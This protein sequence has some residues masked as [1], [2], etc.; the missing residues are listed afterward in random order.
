MRS[1]APPVLYASTATAGGDALGETP[2]LY[3]CSCV[4]VERGWRCV[5]RRPRALREHGYDA[6][7]AA[8]RARLRVRERA[9]GSSPPVFAN[10]LRLAV[11]ESQLALE[12]NH[13]GRPEIDDQSPAMTGRRVS[14]TVVDHSAT[15]KRT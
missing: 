15:V 10:I 3:A 6:S 13:R 5:R 2:V 11:I 9:K 14:A 8:T 1:T 12:P 7:T 4:R